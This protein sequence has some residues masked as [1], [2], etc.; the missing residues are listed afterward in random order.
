VSAGVSR[1]NPQALRFRALAASSEAANLNNGMKAFVDGVE[2]E[3]RLGVGDETGM[4]PVY[5][6]FCG[7]TAPGRSGM[8]ARQNVC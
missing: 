4:T 2:A 8:R 6:V 3:I 7:R 1:V 5:A